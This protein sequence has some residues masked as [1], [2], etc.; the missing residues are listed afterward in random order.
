[1]RHAPRI[2]A[3][4]LLVGMLV[5]PWPARGLRLPA[6]QIDQLV[7]PIALFPDA[8]LSQ[9]LMAASYPLEIVEADRWAQA[10]SNLSEYD[11]IEQL[12]GKT[13]D[14][15]VT[16]LT[17][18]P[19][20][21]RQMSA[22]LD[23]TKDL[24]EAFIA[25]SS[26]VMNAVQRMRA[27]AQSAGNLQSGAQQTVKAEDGVV[28]IV[29]SN[30]QVI[31]VPQYSPTAVYGD[32]WA[33]TSWYYPSAMVASAGYFAGQALAFGVGVA[34]GAWIFGGCDWIHHGVWVNPRV[35][36]GAAY[37][38]AVRYN[39]ININNLDGHRVD[40]HYN[41]IHRGAVNF[42]NATLQQ[43]YGVQAGLSGVN[44]STLRGYGAGPPASVP[45]FARPGG[46]PSWAGERRVSQ[47]TFGSGSNAF[48]GYR[49]SSFENRASDR[50]AYSRGVQG[51]GFSGASSSAPS[52]PAFGGGER[53]FGG[54]R[55]FGGG[56]RR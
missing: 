31:F 53:S 20:V 52:R 39:N 47:P 28:T 10:N 18:F 29:P 2:A 24:G 11:R 55:G 38:G 40:W 4:L 26:A 5:S 41:N 14:P 44:R 45:S 36:G 13:W 21:L 32:D 34:T 9:V 8:L 35:Y 49:P 43:R 33:P 23:W 42:S 27:H 50:G 25:D 48:G 12:S 56:R 16:S 54:G 1:M 46:Q 30:P 22:N 19:D 37:R 7:A 51:A 15:S 3:L 17:A 6:D